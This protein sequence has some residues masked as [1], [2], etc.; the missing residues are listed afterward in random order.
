MHNWAPWKELREE[1]PEERATTQI[2]TEGNVAHS[3]HRREASRWTGSIA[4]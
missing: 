4:S 1:Q 2:P 3:R